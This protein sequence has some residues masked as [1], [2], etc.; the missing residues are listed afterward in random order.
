MTEVDIFVCLSRLHVT[1]ILREYLNVRCKQVQSEKIYNILFNINN[2]L[3]HMS[4]D[5][6]LGNLNPTTL[7]ALA[8]R[9]KTAEQYLSLASFVCLELGGGSSFVY[10]ICLDHLFSLQHQC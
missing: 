7:Q 8:Y 3:L 10:I 5:I 2:Y 1:A 6:I 9:Y 4:C